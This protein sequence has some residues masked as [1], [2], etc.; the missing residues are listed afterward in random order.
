MLSAIDILGIEERENAIEREYLY[1][2]KQYAVVP[3]VIGMEVKEA[4]K[5]LKQFKVEY[6]GNG[7]VITYQ[8]PS[9]GTSIYEGETIR[10]L[11]DE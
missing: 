7:N 3:N 6:S 2:D 10:L 11:L 1:T 8:S 9:S 5:A 4:I